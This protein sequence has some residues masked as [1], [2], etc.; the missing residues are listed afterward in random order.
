MSTSA[1]SAPRPADGLVDR[2][3]AKLLAERQNA[4]AQ[5]TVEK[6]VTVTVEKHYILDTWNFHIV[7]LDGSSRSGAGLASEEAARA[8][9][10]RVLEA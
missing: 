6:H 7:L 10:Q 2:I 1:N 5:V 8:A 9:A 3:A 4:E